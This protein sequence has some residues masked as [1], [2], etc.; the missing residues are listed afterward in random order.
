MHIMTKQ[1]YNDNRQEYVILVARMA[2]RGLLIA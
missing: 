1:M 2:L